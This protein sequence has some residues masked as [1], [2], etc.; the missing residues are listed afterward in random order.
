V[1]DRTERPVKL[2]VFDAGL[3]GERHLNGVLA[4]PGACEKPLATAAADARPGT[5]SSTSNAPS[6]K[7]T[8]QISAQNTCEVARSPVRNGWGQLGDQ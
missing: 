3:I 5:C 1:A 2:A 4:E 8:S 7:C 6:H